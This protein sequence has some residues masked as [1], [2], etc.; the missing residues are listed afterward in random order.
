L[1]RRRRRRGREAATTA[2]ETS[3]KWSTASRLLEYGDPYRSCF[4]GRDFEGREGE[5][6]MM[7]RW[8]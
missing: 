5:E 6:L 7:E 4:R 1:R 8:S 3:T 2:E